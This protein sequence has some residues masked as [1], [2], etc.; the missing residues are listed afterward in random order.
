MAIGLFQGIKPGVVTKVVNILREDLSR[1]LF[2]TMYSKRDHIR[3]VRRELTEAQAE[4]QRLARLDAMTA[5]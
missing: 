1:H 5:R 4:K 2:H 3:R